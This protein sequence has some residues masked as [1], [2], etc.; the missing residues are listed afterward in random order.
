M[1]VVRNVILA[2]AMTSMAMPAAADPLADAVRADMPAL[3]AL[4][5]DFHRNPELSFQEKQTA[6]RLAAEIRKSGFQVTEGV[7]GTGVVA[8]MKN[9]PGPV[10]MIRADMDALPVHEQTGLA[11]ASS[12]KALTPDGLETPV[13]H[14][15]GHDI[16]M[17]AWIGTARRL[18]AMKDRWSG[19]L[20]MIGQPAEELGLG[21]KRML[22][23]GLFTRFPKPGHV[24][25]LHDSASLPAGTIGYSPGYAL[26]NVDSVD[27]TVKGLGGHGSA[28]HTTR[29]PIV[30]ASRIV[31]ALQTLVAREI[32]PQKPG[33]VTVGSFHAGAKHNIIPDEARL[34]LTVRSYDEETRKT[35]LDGI[36]R[37]VR[38]EAMAAGIADDRL[39][40]VKLEE[41]PTPSTFNTE[42]LTGQVAAAFAER[43]GK[44]RVKQIP[45]T[46]AGEDF[47][48]FYLADRT[49]QSMIFWVGGVPQDKWDAAGGD[50]RKLPSL[51][52]PYWAPHPEPTIATGVEAM[53]TA[54][55]TVLAK[56]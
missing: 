46:M 5:R 3:L 33:V 49:I 32:D 30:L 9:G 2:A 11:Y 25:A 56:D 39:P 4:Y 52:S 31:S 45:P 1:R 21:A 14:A 29:D 6:A 8:V 28:P 44:D 20:V 48:R 16:H 51:H 38:G 7:G 10:L 18:V 47:G 34:Q 54:A 41:T 43:F 42:P 50:A 26:A 40:E 55:L 27:V 12:A 53:V 19:T 13:M 23:D 37:I 17:T 22:D 24:L 15:C 36:A 35:L